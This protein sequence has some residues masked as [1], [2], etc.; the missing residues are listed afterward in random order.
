[1]C[2][3]VIQPINLFNLQTCLLC[4]SHW[5]YKR[6]L[7][8]KEAQFSRGDN[9]QTNSFHPVTSNGVDRSSQVYTEEGGISRSIT[10]QGTGRWN[11]WP[12]RCWDA[13][14]SWQKVS[15]CSHR[16]VE[17]NIVQ[18]GCRGWQMSR[19]WRWGYKETGTWLGG[20]LYAVEGR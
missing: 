11:S 20:F 1:M 17:S 4:A 14:H 15:V 3:P 19:Q 7:S 6:F 8:S 18:Y 12:I 5:D 13:G 2:F 10:G 16:A 9:M